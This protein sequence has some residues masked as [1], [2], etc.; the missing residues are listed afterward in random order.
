MAAHRTVGG[1]PTAIDW[2]E[3]HDDLPGNVLGTAHAFT[4]FAPMPWWAVPMLKF[5]LGIVKLLPTTDLRRHHFVYFGRWTLLPRVP[6]TGKRGDRYVLI[7]TNFNGSFS[8]YLD[9]LSVALWT[10]LTRIWGRCYEC[11]PNMQPPSSFRRWARRHELPAQHYFCAYPEA[12]VKQIEMALVKEA[13]GSDAE[14][15]KA[16]RETPE[17]SLLERLR[18][19]PARLF[20]PDRAAPVGASP[21]VVKKD[22]VSAV[23][24]LT[25]VLP[26]QLEALTQRLHRIDAAARSPDGEGS[27]FEQVEG[28]HVARWV[29]LDQLVN[30]KLSD[31]PRDAKPP[32][33]LFGAVG[34]GMPLAFLDRL[35]RELPDDALDV[36]RVHCKGVDSVP[37]DRYLWGHRLPGGLLYA[38]FRASRGAVRHA[39]AAAAADAAPA[40]EPAAAP[41]ASVTEVREGDHADI[42]GNLVRGYRFPFGAFLLVRIGDPAGGR[43]WLQHLLRQGVTTARAQE[44]EPA[45]AWNVAFTFP[46]LRML[47]V[48]NRLL[49]P[50]PEDFRQGMEARAKP[51]GDVDGN[52]PRGWERGL[53]D[54]DGGHV[55]LM[56]RTGDRDRRNAQMKRAKDLIKAD[57]LE[58][59]YEEVSDPLPR[60]P[61]DA[62]KC[63]PGDREHFDFADGCSQPTIGG[64]WEVRPGEL[65]LGYLDGDGMLPGAARFFRNGTFMVF[66]KLEQRVD[67]FNAILDRY[68]DRPLERELVAAKIVG[69]WRDGQPLVL[70][71]QEDQEDGVRDPVVLNDF[72]YRSEDPHGFR[73]PLG[74]HIRRAFPRDALVGGERQTGRHRILRRGM[75]YDRP[76]EGQRERK[77]GLL[78]I[79]FNASIARQ[80]ETVQ[81]WCLDGNLFDVPG[82]PDFL[83]GPAPA[84]M[85]IQREEGPLQLTRT[86]PLVV[87]RGGGYFF[88][89]GLAALEA[90]AKRDYLGQCEGIPR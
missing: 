42:Q 77:R 31:T 72:R 47:G 8:D 13:T 55:M 22:P 18:G 15:V 12:T 26:N 25:P 76:A 73:C 84:T 67:D 5:K 89:P 46:G 68:A 23:T 69:R 29:V 87:T 74:A 88:Y 11:P 3:W 43:A 85:T 75:P 36:W 59:A 21:H 9:T 27:P 51:L 7:E 19:F 2:P 48:P 10:N 50:F 71:R 37:L 62:Q 80:F 39:L 70:D 45:E 60:D 78:F 6:G 52:D 28:T 35:C 81:G 90:I 44:E 49:R 30:E 17:L 41:G 16:I 53:R 65:L 20:L 40:P 57:G 34:D 64:D 33:L 83:L 86:K 1:I 56:L 38:G 63:G 66:R 79:C 61:G 54:S 14:A 4:A 24:T 58:V 82:E 32:M